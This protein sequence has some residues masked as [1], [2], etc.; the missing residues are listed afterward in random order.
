MV[1]ESTARGFRQGPTSLAPPLLRDAHIDALVR[2]IVGYASWTVWYANWTL[3][4]PLWTLWYPLWTHWYPPW[5]L[6]W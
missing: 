2:C 4:Y 1:V 3:W 6:W 5:T